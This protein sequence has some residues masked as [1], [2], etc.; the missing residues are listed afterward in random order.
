MSPDGKRTMLSGHITRDEVLGGMSGRAAK[1]ASTLLALIETQTAYLVA[2]ARLAMAPYRTEQAATERNHAFLEALAVGREPP[3]P[4][5]I[6]D[7]ERWALHWGSL[8]P[9]NPTLRAMVAHLLGQKYSFTRHVTPRL[10]AVL[11]LNTPP[12]LEAYNRLYATPL[13]SI[14]ANQLQPAEH[15]RWWRARPGTWLDDLP[16]FWTAFALTLT[17]TVGASILALPI[18]VARIGPLAGVALLLLFGLVNVVTIAWMAEALT[19]T[20]SIRYGKT[21]MDRVVRDYLGNASA[22][23]LSLSTLVYCVLALITYYIGF[24]TSLAG[25]TSIPAWAWVG[26]LF[27]VNVYF[28]QRRTLNATVASALL[29]GAFNL[30]LIL[31]IS[32]FAFSQAQPMRW[33]YVAIPG[34]NGQPSGPAVLQL[35]LGVVLGVYAG[36][37]SVSN[38]A[39]VVLRRDPSGRSLIHG[40]VAAL[41]TAIALF[42]VWVMAINGAI[43]PSVLARETGTALVPL[44]AQL[45]APVWVAGTLYT[46][47]GIG[48]IS[49]HTSLGLYNLAREWL[50]RLQR[51]SGAGSAR[52]RGL[53]LLSPMTA[54]FLLSEWLLLTGSGSFA[55]LSSLRGALLAPLLAGIFPALLLLVSRRKGEIVPGTL[56]RWLGHSWLVGGIFLLFITSLLLHGSVLWTDLPRRLVALLLGGLLLGLTAWLAHRHVLDR[57]MVIEL[58]HDERKGRASS[59]VATTGGEPLI[60]TVRLRYIGSEQQIQAASG[61]I[62]TFAALR[63]ASFAV[64]TDGAREIKVGAYR[65]TPEGEP[66]ALTGTLVLHTAKESRTYD[67]ARSDGQIIVPLPAAM[68]EVEIRLQDREA[69]T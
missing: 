13:A 51:G 7:L 67:L 4:A 65:I 60:A 33:W 45:G 61:N 32:L 69:V 3:V 29:I 9:E 25:A 14:Y 58:H 27:A 43:D 30:G 20:S 39:E 24:G 18:A 21:Y 48:M 46:V 47:L 66:G 62:S 57:R 56:Y 10:Q 26:L 42:C 49:I 22:T 15:L 50:S 54:I 1:Q 8:V 41:L 23:V 12:V 64:P 53:L 11:G 68:H 19:R 17:N 5:R 34:I 35:A 52:W 63:S 38:C 59:F 55:Q 16:P 6:Q 36:H 44:A 37:L 31:I 40:A 28:V 2:Q